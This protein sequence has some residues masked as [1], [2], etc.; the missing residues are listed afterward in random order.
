L[1]AFRTRQSLPKHCWRSVATG[2]DPKSVDAVIITHMHPDQINGPLRVDG[3]L[4]FPNVEVLVPAAER[5]FWFD[6][7]EKAGDGYREVPALW[8]PTMSL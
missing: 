6:D 7:G 4:A 2:I 5:A 3:T 1:F 8:N